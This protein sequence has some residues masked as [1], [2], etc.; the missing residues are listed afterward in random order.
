[1]QMLFLAMLV[2]AFHATLENRVIPDLNS[3]LTIALAKH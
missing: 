3:K 2:N 1:M